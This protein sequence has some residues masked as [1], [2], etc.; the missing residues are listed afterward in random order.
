MTKKENGVEVI[1]NSVLI[2]YHDPLFTPV[3]DPL[4]HFSVYLLFILL[5]YYHL[6][7]KYQ[8]KRNQECTDNRTHV[9]ID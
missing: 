4:F 9:C 6:R 1:P 2:L 3:K 8:T 7:I 5:F